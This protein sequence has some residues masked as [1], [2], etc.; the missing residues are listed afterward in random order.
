MCSFTAIA[1]Q[2]PPTEPG[3]DRKSLRARFAVAGPRGSGFDGVATQPSNTKDHEDD[4]ERQG[5]TTGILERFH[6]TLLDEHFRVE[7]RRTSFETI[8]EMQ[9]VLDNYLEGYNTR[10]PHQGRGM[11]GRTP[12]HAFTDGVSKTSNTEVTCQTTKAKLKAA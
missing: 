4:D 3:A 11:N 9:A 7:E 2:R 1:L 12:I 5:S 10:W 8:E 6:R